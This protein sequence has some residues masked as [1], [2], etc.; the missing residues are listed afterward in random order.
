MDKHSA[1]FFVDACVP[2]GAPGF[3]CPSC[4]CPLQFIG[5]RVGGRRDVEM[6]D[7]YRCPAS[8]GTFEYERKRH[9]LRLLVD[10]CAPDDTGV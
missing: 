2:C 6:N 10:G 5:S 1:P 7:Y 9:R 4:E 8:C 3:F